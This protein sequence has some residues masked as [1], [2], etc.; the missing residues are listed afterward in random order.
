MSFSLCMQYLNIYLLSVSPTPQVEWVKLGHPLPDK[1]KVEN[2]GKFLIVPRVEQEDSGKYRCKARNTL[3][4]VDS[5]FIVTVEGNY[6]VLC[7]CNGAF[8]SNLY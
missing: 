2:H 3:G 8:L 7:S 5:Y 6:N 4:E 1:A